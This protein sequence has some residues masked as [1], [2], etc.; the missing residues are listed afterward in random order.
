MWRQGDVLIAPVAALPDGATQCTTNI[1][2][3]GEISGH[4][5]RVVLPSTAE[6]W[7]RGDDLFLS[8]RA[9]AATIVH[10]EHRS[11]TV[12]HGVYRVWSQREYIAAHLAPRPVL[13]ERDDDDVFLIL[14]GA[15]LID[16]DEDTGGERRLLRVTTSDEDVV[17][18]AVT[19][20]SSGKRYRIR[21]PPTARTCRAAAAWVAGFDNPDEYQPILET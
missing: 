10:E 18:L 5:H 12:P 20:P 2:A 11:V 4:S 21:V 6:L 13:P 8:V 3:H 9:R 15:Q 19:C 14:A 17:C 16:R 1:L 7:E